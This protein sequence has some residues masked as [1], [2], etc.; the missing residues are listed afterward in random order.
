MLAIRWSLNVAT[1]VVGGV[2]TLTANHDLM[3]VNAEAT[4]FSKDPVAFGLLVEPSERK[5][6]R[7]VHCRCYLAPSSFSRIHACHSGYASTFVR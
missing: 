5:E 4:G 1:Q 7:Q 3:I 2:R 6:L